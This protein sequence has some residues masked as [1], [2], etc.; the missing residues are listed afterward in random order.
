VRFSV[1]GPL[2]RGLAA[3]FS[4]AAVLGVAFAVVVFAQVVLRPMLGLSDNGDFDRVTQP[5]GLVSPDWDQRNGYVNP[6]WTFG[7][8]KET[9]YWSSLLP[10]LHLLVDGSRRLG[11]D[12]FDLR[13]LGA[14]YAVAAGLCVWLLIRAL[15]GRLLQIVV[16]VPLILVLGDSAFVGYL[17]SFYSEPSSLIGLLLVLAVVFGVRGRRR[18]PAWQLALAAL[19]AALL[20]LAKAQNVSLLLVLVPALCLLKPRKVSVALGLALAVAGGVY[21]HNGPPG[22]QGFYVYDTVFVSIL[23]H[24]PDPEGDL[25]ELGLDPGLVR[26]THSTVYHNG[27]YLDPSFQRLLASGGH[28]KLYAFYLHHPGRALGLAVRATRDTAELRPSYLGNRVPGDGYPRTTMACELC[29]YSSTS[30]ALKPAAP[31][32]LPAMYLLAFLAVRR[33]RRRARQD[34][35]L[36]AGTGTELRTLSD[37]LA[38]TALLG[39]LSFATAVGAEGDFELVKHLY[40]FEVLTGVL[41]FLLVAGGVLE[42][43]HRRAG[44][45]LAPLE[46]P[47]FDGGPTSDRAPASRLTRA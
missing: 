20:V 37:G 39:L 13:W 35:G 40:L 34:F 1:A 32:L 9:P 19:A 11:A 24:S 25:R 7:P 21:L 6:L 3:R 47:A 46:P 5:L 18:L 16:G 8:K 33:L 38:V 23:P 36:P 4:L 26:Y 22:I 43:R 42:L 28:R 44:R 29:L 31:V 41:G 30:R 2:T 27:N 15:P 14:F 45:Q 10:L 17:G 12:F